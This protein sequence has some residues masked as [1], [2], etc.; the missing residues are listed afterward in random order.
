[1]EGS[2]PNSEKDSPRFALGVASF[3]DKVE[4]QTNTGSE[5]KNNKLF[6]A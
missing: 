3:R 5:K 4:E 1:M 2:S 6:A